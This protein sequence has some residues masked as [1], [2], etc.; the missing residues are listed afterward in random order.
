[1]V[2]VA[3]GSIFGGDFVKMGRRKTIIAQNVVGLISSGISIL[4]NFYMIC[5]GRLVFGF[6]CGVLLCTTPRMLDETIPPHL[7]D[8]G[9]GNSTNIV[10]NFA[11]LVVMLLAVFLPEERENQNRFWVVVLAVQVPF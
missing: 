9:F 2:G 11:F 6:S 5:F 3:F 8:R 4:P 1:M 7:I 10:T